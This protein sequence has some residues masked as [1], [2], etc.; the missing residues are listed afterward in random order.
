M[1]ELVLPRQV[2]VQ[3][4]LTDGPLATSIGVV[5][6]SP[7]LVSVL[8]IG[9]AYRDEQLAAAILP[10]LLANSQGVSEDDV[11]EEA[12]DWAQRL[13]AAAAKRRQPKAEKLSGE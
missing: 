9:G 7:G 13:M 12:L 10:G 5:Q 6:A 2:Q 8:A 4:S 3:T 11:L 1:S